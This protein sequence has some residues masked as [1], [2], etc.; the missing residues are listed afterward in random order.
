M[1]I[2]VISH[3]VFSKTGNMG[4]TLLG[5]F[6]GFQKEELA[7]FYI[8]SEVP[9]DDSKCVEYFRFTDR[10]ALKSILF[11]CAKGKVFS[12]KDIDKTRVTTRT[13]KGVAGAIYQLGRKRTGCIYLARNTLW[14]LSRW[15]TS[16]LKA[17]LTEIAPD[18]VFFASGD[19][20]FMYKVANKIVEYLGIPM[21]V[22]CVDD[23]YIHNKNQKS[24]IGRLEHKAFMNTVRKALNRATCILS[25]CDAMSEQYSQLFQKPCY[26]L[27]TPAPIKELNLDQDARA[28]SYIGNLGYQRH[29]QVI[30]IAR[31]I[32]K[33]CPELYVDVY[34]GERREDIIR[35]LES[36]PGIR[37]NGSISAEEVYAVM[38]KSKIVIHTESF[39]PAIQDRVRFSVS[40]KI[41]EILMNGPC[42]LAYGPRGIASIDYLENHRAAYVITSK[43][44]LEEGLK[45][46][47]GNKEL[48]TKII[49]NAR[50]LAQ[51]NHRTEVNS[52]NVRRWLEDAIASK[53]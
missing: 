37:F 20:S 14:G 10:D 9:T 51:T 5:Y 25:I 38:E 28:I 19:Y 18:V 8:H 32:Q 11:Q 17:W 23:Y 48:Y 33:I 35:A 15:F 53:E 47:L 16:D 24:F 41:A 12:H 22:A 49:S 29:E 50:I 42:L 34:S 21:I 4:K 3:T 44:K 40:T 6:D 1:K 27:H 26:T 43:D 30:E 13:D 45:E 52:T 7:Q 36:E 31:V 2:L 39:D 46:I